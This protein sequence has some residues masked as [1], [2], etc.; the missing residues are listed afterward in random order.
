MGPRNAP[1]W[2]Q[3]GSLVVLDRSFR[4]LIFRF[5]FGSFSAPFGVVLGCPN[6][7]HRVSVNWGYPP[8]PGDPRRCYDRLGSVPRSTC[9]LGSLVKPL[10]LLLGPYLGL[11]GTNF[12][13]VGVVAGSFFYFALS[14][15]AGRFFLC[16]T[17]RVSCFDYVGPGPADCVLRD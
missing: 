11:L 9:G 12:R 8:T 10:G 5:D 16:S 15:F 4:L 14:I 17:S 6:G 2:C 1:K 13:F 7:P 3:D